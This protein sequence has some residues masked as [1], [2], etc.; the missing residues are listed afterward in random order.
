[1]PSINISV[2]KRAGENIIKIIEIT[3]KI[4]KQHIQQL[5][6]GIKVAKLMDQSKDIANMVSDLENNIISGLILVIA[7]LFFVLGFRNA[8]LVALSIPFSMLISF[9]I[10]HLLDITL[11]MVVLFSLTLALG[12]L[13][14]NA[15][16]IIEN[17]YRYREFGFNRI[18]AK[19]SKT[20]PKRA[21]IR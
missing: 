2:K 15:I 10:L 14:D 4:I 6:S 16:V 7:V 20:I 5:S 19:R 21:V 8:V 12:M 1:M 13:V 18:K 3:D 9:I 17:I 11:N